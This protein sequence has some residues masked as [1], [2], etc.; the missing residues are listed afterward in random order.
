MPQQVAQKDPQRAKDL[1]IQRRQLLLQAKKDS[2]DDPEAYLKAIQQAQQLFDQAQQLGGAS[3]DDMQH[4]AMMGSA[5]TVASPEEPKKDKEEETEKAILVDVELDDSVLK[6]AGHKYV[7]REPTGKPKPKYRYWYKVP[8]RG[9]VSSDGLKVGSKLQ[10]GTD[11]KAGHY[12]VVSGPDEE[13]KY[14]LKHDETGHEDEMTAEQIKD[15]IHTHHAEVKRKKEHGDQD[16]R[17]TQDLQEAAH[18]G[19]PDAMEEAA[20]SLVGHREEGQS[21]E[22]AKAF[23]FSLYDKYQDEDNDAAFADLDPLLDSLMDGTISGKEAKGKA[24]AIVK[25]YKDAEEESRTRVRTKE[26]V[27]DLFDIGEMELHSSK[28]DKIFNVYADFKEESEGTDD[29]DEDEYGSFVDPMDSA[30]GAL[31]L[32]GI[33]SQK[34]RDL[35]SNFPLYKD[36][37]EARRDELKAKEKEE[38][39]KVDIHSDYNRERRLSW[40]NE[41]DGW[42]KNLDQHREHA[43]YGFRH[44]GELGAYYYEA[45][46]NEEK[47][48]ELWDKYGISLAP[49]EDAINTPMNDLPIADDVYKK[50]MGELD[51]LNKVFDV[52]SVLAREGVTLSVDPGWNTTSEEKWGTQ[53]KRGTL[54]KYN[55]KQHHIS[56]LRPD[57]QGET[58]VHELFHLLDWAGGRGNSLSD[59]S[60]RSEEVNADVFGGDGEGSVSHF[61]S[62]E[63]PKHKE[64]Y[65]ASDSFNEYQSRPHE[66]FA[67][68]MEE[69]VHDA[70]G[71]TKSESR[72]VVDD[73]YGDLK[74]TTGTGY[75]G[76]EF[77]SKNAD[78]I[79]KVAENI[80]I[81]VRPEYVQAVKDAKEHP[82]IT[83]AKRK[84]EEEAQ[85]A[86]S[87]IDKLHEESKGKDWGSLSEDDREDL[88]N[89]YDKIV[90]DL[91]RQAKTVKDD[92]VKKELKT[93]IRSF[94]FPNQMDAIYD[95]EDPRSA[96]ENITGMRDEISR[97]MGKAL[98]LVP[99]PL[100]RVADLVK[101]AGHK[102]VKREPTGK[103]SPKYRYWYKT[104]KGE[105]VSSDGMKAGDKFA[106]GEGKNEGHYEVMTGEDPKGM[107]LL[108]H[109]VTDHEL[110]M[111]AED[112][113]DFIERQKSQKER[114]DRHSKK[115]EE[116][117]D[118]VS[119]HAESMD[120]EQ[121][122]EAVNSL[123]Q[124]RTKQQKERDE[125][126]KNK[127]KK[128]VEAYNQRNNRWLDQIFSERSAEKVKTF[129]DASKFLCG[130]NDDDTLEYTM[131]VKRYQR[132]A[133]F[134]GNRVDGDFDWMNVYD[135]EGKPV[136][137]TF[138]REFDMIDPTDPNEAVSH[139]ISEW[140]TIDK[141]NPIINLYNDELSVVSSQ[142]GTGFAAQL[143]ARQE[144][145]LK[146]ATQ[147]LPDE[148]KANVVVTITADINVGKYYW[149]TQGFRYKTDKSRGDHLY[150]LAEGIDSARDEERNV[151]QDGGWKNLAARDENGEEKTLEDLGYPA[152]VLDALRSK[153]MAESQR[154]RD[155]N[156]PADEK[157]EPWEV[158]ELEPDVPGAKPLFVKNVD[159]DEPKLI[160]C[161][162]MKYL[163]L[164]GDDW[165]SIKH[166]HGP[167]QKDR[168]GIAVGDQGRAA[169]AIKAA[170]RERPWDWLGTD[171]KPAYDDIHMGVRKSVLSMV[172]L[173]GSNYFSEDEL[174]TGAVL[175]G[176]ALDRSFTTITKGKTHKYAKRELTGKPKPKYR[177]WY[178]LPGGGLV[179][180]SALHVGAKFRH[181]KGDVAGH[182]EITEDLG[183]GRYK[184]KH[185][186]TGEEHY[187][188]EQGLRSM[189]HHGEHEVAGQTMETSMEAMRRKMDAFKQAWLHGTDKQ[190]EGR[191][192]D[193]LKFAE[194]YFGERGKQRAINSMGRIESGYDRG[195]K[196]TTTTAPTQPTAP[197]AP[198]DDKQKAKAKVKKIVD[199]Y[200]KQDDTWL[201]GVL[202]SADTIASDLRYP[203]LRE[204]VPPGEIDTFEKANQFLIGT[205]YEEELLATERY[206]KVAEFGGYQVDGDDIDDLEVKTA[207]G[208]PVTVAFGR[209][210][211]IKPAG[212]IPSAMK[213][214]DP[215]QPMIDLHNDILEIEPDQRGSGFAPQL[216]ARQEDY[217]KKATDKLPDAMKKNVVVTI[218]ADINVGKYYWTTQGFRYRSNVTRVKH[219]NSL[220]GM[221][222]RAINPDT[223]VE[224]PRKWDDEVA[225][226][227]KDGNLKTLQDLGYSREK[228]NDL[229]LKMQEL[230]D[231]AQETSVSNDEK[232]EPWDLLELEPDGPGGPVFVRNRESDEPKF[233]KCGVMKFLMLGGDSWGAIKHVHGPTQKDRDGIAI[234]EQN[235]AALAAKSA[236][237]GKPWEWLGED[238]NRELREEFSKSMVSYRTN[239]SRIH[240]AGSFTVRLPRKK[241]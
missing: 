9:L 37:L 39:E 72:S 152:D 184:I 195:S 40:M 15:L 121:L 65:S 228:L 4:I 27:D 43:G 168:D 172:R 76:R 129:E 47:A 180:S 111:T 126:A 60:E 159:S 38:R 201:N 46:T 185:D 110:R 109:N 63:V 94:G 85:A 150:T 115:D 84:K 197:T 156:I 96:F 75:W 189:I 79:A 91:F 209:R 139:N 207:D 88:F 181:G 208:T 102:Y 164:N 34:S 147:N 215:N 206:K 238:A 182:H 31:D 71:S 19:D 163:M 78:K 205:T 6:G 68:L 191:R 155:P 24:Q 66:R 2:A 225:A 103:P 183:G 112:M 61:I 235:R 101:G 232:F 77:H 212:A 29:E 177:Y 216:Y 211:K 108:R 57:A 146:R 74:E 165:K 187:V 12:E 176:K 151:D 236:A 32:E 202:T 98:P 44:S 52:R 62:S 199:A 175:V 73:G 141:S 194:G 118:D 153:L 58:F 69:F 41:K 117:V 80:G 22:D 82:K 136:T 14:K 221:L 35:I 160:K 204:S 132:V 87:K 171:L 128:M 120:H 144:E 36:A 13:G 50:F 28:L 21:F 230:R 166:V 234:G 198:A 227:D 135:S 210:F 173:D 213:T 81:K 231:K 229:Y 192:Q 174:F 45:G 158:L 124:H 217:L 226:Y 196:R 23:I 137:E 167:T 25:K 8:G 133:T 130:N 48:Q 113:T 55:T 190:V 145:Y 178:R 193:Y 138:I 170:G 105:L 188:S 90:R 218:A 224:P 203:G 223:N 18:S 42:K 240:K 97:H 157:M 5:N 214:L 70:F 33:P 95:G 142:R 1:L 107:H 241:K 7:K 86:Q 51:A 54:A 123:L 186:E 161:G 179:T 16:E 116:L 83:E 67:R 169:A 30:V 134:G 233:I 93:K 26:D 89:H 17:L 92:G 220:I 119:R 56:L 148:L 106:H 100:V 125:K 99:P 200:H 239:Q 64:H 219:V 59:P 140:A 122:S 143:Y 237:K 154:A 53:A 222:E 49:P 104:P 114:K 3:A 10:H 149:A 11:D 127:A 20:D 162:L 131:A